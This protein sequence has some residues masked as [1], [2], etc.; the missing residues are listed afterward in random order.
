MIVLDSGPVIAMT[1]NNL[2]WAF[3][4]LKRLH[5]SDILM[6]LSVKRELVDRG[7]ETQR[8]KF[9]AIQVGSYVRDGTFHVV[10]DE[11]VKK[12]TDL[13]LRVANRILTV[14]KR[15]VRIVQRGEMEAVATAIVFDAD[16]I[17]VDERTTRTMIESPEELRGLMEHRLH[18]RLKV[19]RQA[20]K[21]FQEEVKGVFIMRSIELVMVAYEHGLLDRYIIDIPNARTRLLESLLWGMKTEGC[22]VTVQEINELVRQHADRA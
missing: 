13:L 11:R 14:G 18:K 2:L 7:L 19:D 10:D 21:R 12:K 20:L 1:A 9:E 17:V 6:P 15:N 22:S 5:G 3:R 16:A 8:F 4:D